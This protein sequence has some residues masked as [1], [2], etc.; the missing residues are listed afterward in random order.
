MRTRRHG[1]FAAGRFAP[2]ISLE[3]KYLRPVP[4]GGR[5]MVEARLTRCAKKII[6]AACEAWMEGSR[7]DLMATAEGTYYVV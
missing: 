3:T 2:T 7:D 5:L 4:T 6:F 1:C